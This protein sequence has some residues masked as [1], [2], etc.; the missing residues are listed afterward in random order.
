MNYIDF[1]IHI[2]FYD[3]PEDIIEK[4][5]NHRIY[6]LFVTNLPELFEK[7]YKSTAK[8]KYVRLALGY[9][10]EMISQYEFNKDLFIKMNI[11]LAP[12][13]ID[14]AVSSR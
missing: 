13:R 12:H 4:Y 8:Y 2:D 1:H 6:C 3:K 10:P 14:Y 11:K 7:H 5:E 9:H